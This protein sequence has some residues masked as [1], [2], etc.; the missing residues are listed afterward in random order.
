MADN[1]SRTIL[2][3]DDNPPT[4]YST[5]RVL[6]AAGFEVIEAATGQE[7]VAKASCNPDLVI[8]D[9]NLPDIDGFEVC[10]ILRGMPL[11]ARTP[12][13]HLSATFV[14][15]VDKVQG[16]EAGA[17]GYLTHPVE[18]P[19]LVA[20]VNAFLRTRYAE[21]AMRA[22]EAKFKALFDNAPNGIAL[23]T[24]EMIYVEA[25]PA[26]C[27]TLGRERDA[28]VGRHITAF[29]PQESIEQLSAVTQELDQSGAW[30]GN[31]PVL[32]A[33]GQPVHLEWAVSIHSVPGTRLAITTD[34]T[35]RRLIEAD[36]ERLL[37]SERAARSEAERANRLKDEFLAALSH[38]LRTPLGAILGWSDVLKH[39]LG[40]TEPD[41]AKALEAIDRNA[42]VQTQLI[43]DLLDVSRITSGKLSL[44]LQW[45]DARTALDTALTAFVATA[46]NKE[47]EITVVHEGPAADLCWDPA[48]F[49]QVVW[50]LTDN[51]LKFSERGGQIEVR[52]RVDDTV[53][54]LSV[55]DTGRGI[56]P[57]FLPHIFERFR[58][59]DAS[60]RRRHG[61][62][63]LGL[64]IVKEVVEAHGATI[65]AD[66]EGERRGATF[67]V[68]MPRV[69]RHS[70]SPHLRPLTAHDLRGARIL[71]VDDDPDAR[72]L[73]ARLLGDARAQVL[74]AADV[75]AAIALMH[76][77]PPDLVISD[78]G[79]PGEDGYDFIRQLRTHAGPEA[80]PAIALTAF[81]GDEDRQ[82]ALQAGYQDH[83]GKPLDTRKLIE[84]AARLLSQART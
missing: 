68:R 82:R 7:A 25:N 20:T 69:K 52:L 23:L 76:R 34:I 27:R 36:R 48:R 16:L 26:L 55:R 58:Q 5:G 12:V 4:R 71:V 73:I 75:P 81:V 33:I 65:T 15:D 54:D 49:Q 47:V 46:R 30:R 14:N 84:A 1:R 56:A 3:V 37:A 50:N 29:L 64:A 72:A 32:D 39:Q 74:V 19:V 13:I 40:N 80:I 11:T 2:V 77:E 62:L 60:T 59:E 43:S 78:L 61:G 51:A 53:I 41:I 44:D 70:S 45:F 24:S 18:P 31:L 66:S 28:I 83:L 35:E 79:M 42:R 8:L 9:V 10:R 22:S 21:E 17:D 6:R 67:T 38:E 57:E 63:G